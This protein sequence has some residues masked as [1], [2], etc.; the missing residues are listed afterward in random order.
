MKQWGTYLLKPSIIWC[1]NPDTSTPL[2]VKEF[3]EQALQNVVDMQDAIIVQHIFQKHYANQCRQE[4]PNI[5]KGNMVCLS[6]VNLSLLK[7]RAGKLLPKFIGPYKILQALPETSNYVLE[8][9]K[10]LLK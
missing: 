1:V 7:G 2:G 6:T 10:E 5:K 4:E 8:L 3:A 9:P